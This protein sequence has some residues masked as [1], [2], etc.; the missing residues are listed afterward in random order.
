MRGL[1]SRECEYR[2]V[3]LRIIRILAKFLRDFIFVRIHVA[4]VFA[5]K[6]I[7]EKIPGELFMYRFRTRGQSRNLLRGTV[8]SK[9]IFDN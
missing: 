2:K 6:S 8:T 7:Q 4:P 3:F 9:G 5:P 1:Y